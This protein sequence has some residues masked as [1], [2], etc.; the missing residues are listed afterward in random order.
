MTVLTIQLTGIG[1]CLFRLK[2]SW[3]DQALWFLLQFVKCIS[4]SYKVREQGQYLTS[5]SLLGDSLKSWE[6]C[7]NH[8]NRSSFKGR[9][10]ICLLKCKRLKIQQ[11]SSDECLLAPSQ[12]TLWSTYTYS[13]DSSIFHDICRVKKPFFGMTSPIANIWLSGVPLNF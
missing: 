9:T 7:K 11:R 4:I 8:T 6:H 3:Q 13:G 5:F 1:I 12:Q 2:T 10:E